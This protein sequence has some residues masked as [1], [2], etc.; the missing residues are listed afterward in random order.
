M[1]FGTGYTQFALPGA[2]PRIT[3][4]TRL[5]TLEIRIGTEEKQ[6]IIRSPVDP[7]RFLDVGYRFDTLARKLC[8]NTRG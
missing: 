3:S 5:E 4:S 2:R 7:S 8:P 6:A 1:P